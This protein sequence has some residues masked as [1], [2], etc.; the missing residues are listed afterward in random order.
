MENLIFDGM[1]AEIRAEDIKRHPEVAK[2]L[3]STSHSKECFPDTMPLFLNTLLSKIRRAIRSRN[4]N[5]RSAIDLD[6]S[7]R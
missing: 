7:I 5:Q 3:P 1:T 4:T 6:R 2:H